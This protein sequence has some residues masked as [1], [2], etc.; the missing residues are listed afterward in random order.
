[1][2]KIE[3]VQFFFL[4]SNSLFVLEKTNSSIYPNM[5]REME[6]SHHF[7][8]HKNSSI[9]HLKITVKKIPSRYA[10]S[11]AT[12]F[13]DVNHR[14]PSLLWSESISYT[15]EEKPSRRRPIEPLIKGTKSNLLEIG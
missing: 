1:M 2:Y 5:S 7:A 9:I 6:E 4:I 3:I 15:L 14:V 13:Y 12:I 11:R 10:F 8:T